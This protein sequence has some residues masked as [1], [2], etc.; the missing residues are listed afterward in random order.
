VWLLSRRVPAEWLDFVVGDL[1]EEFHTR[2]ARGRR[3]ARWWIWKQTLRCFAAPPRVGARGAEAASSAASGDSMIYRFASDIRY[4]TRVLWRAPAFA[5]A[6]VAVLALGIGANTAIFSIVNAVLLRPLPFEEPDRLVRLFHVPPQN[7]F[8]GMPRFPLSA[9]NFYDWQREARM[10]EGMAMYR[11]RQFTLTGTGQPQ[12]VMA[13]AVGAGFFDLLGVRPALGRAFLPEEDSPGRG[14][15]VVLSERFWRSHFGG[16]ADVVGRGLRLDGEPYAVVGVMPARFSV[17]SWAVT[18]RDMWVPMA[19]GEADREVRENHNHQAI[20][21]L[22]DGAMPA[23]ARAELEAISGRLERA[24]PQENAGW[25]A[26]LVPLQEL[27]VEDIRPMLW[28]LFAAVALVLLIACANVANLLFARAVGRRKEIAIRAALGA[29]RGR[30]FQQLLIEAFVLALAGGVAGLLLARAC[31]SAGAALLAS[32][33]PR[34][35][36]ITTDTRVLLF[37]IAASVLTGVLA[38]ALPALRAG[39]TALIDALKEGGRYDGTMGVRTRRVL[40]VGE[41]ALSVVLLMGAAV[42]FRSLLALRHVDAGYDPDHVL[43]LRV[44]LPETRYPDAGRISAFFDAALER[45]RA[46][47]GVQEA[48]GIDD[49]PSQGGS[50]QAVVLEGRSE[51]SP[52]DQPTVEVRKIT[53]GYLRAMGIGLDRGRDVREGDEEVLL[54]SR[55]AA[56]LLWGDQDPIGSRVTL[57]LQSRSVLK[58]VVGVVGDVKQGELS[59]AAAPTVYEYT[60]THSWASLVLVM[61]TSVPPESIAQAAAGVVRA[62]DPEQPVDDLRTMD[63]VLDE[64]IT[65]Q[66]FSATLLGI[67]AAVALAL[68][69]VGIYSVLSYIVRGRTREIGIRTALGAST[70]DVLRLV[71]A[72]GMTPAAVGIG[73]GAVAAL[74]SGALLKRLVFGISA[75]DPL[76]LALVSGVLAAVAFV[77]SLLPAYRAAQLDPSKVLRGNS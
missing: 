37:A 24:Y 17:G 4:A 73:T 43:T 55:T 70:A 76:T 64:T 42:T 1:E 18:A 26:T 53:P 57:P 61:R 72:E 41:V 66:R 9:A 28:L 58:Q 62:I 40:I 8:P 2:A 19:L 46:L 63:D 16:A 59:G 54:V 38:G 68:S 6:V 65:S 67:F 12:S 77:A 25:G 34:A 36:E 7:A 35:D 31:L 74:A 20:A 15:V 60:K 29:G 21:R 14:R 39:T 50:V 75:S 5:L 13:G 27:I 69:S 49:L 56:R 32:Q 3:A 30:V 33:V 48:G 47:P 10:F 11:F 44:S 22:R 45:L 71:I 23:Q 51:L 52:R